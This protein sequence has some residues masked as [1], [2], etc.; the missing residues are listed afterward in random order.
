MTLRELGT[1]VEGVA[2][3]AAIN[4]SEP[5][6]VA[7]LAV[8]F[9]KAQQHYVAEGCG[10]V[11]RT[12]VPPQ[13][14]REARGAL[15]DALAALERCSDDGTEPELLTVKQ[16][17][18]RFNIGERTIYRIIKNGLPVSRA[19]KAVRIKPADLAK[20]LE[21]EGTRLR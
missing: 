2:A 14:L 18:K 13:T 4:E 15:A 3:R 8:A 1:Y 10:D 9:V 6:D 20:A 16:A 21:Y 5:D 17:A 7:G 12:L 11:V 19:G